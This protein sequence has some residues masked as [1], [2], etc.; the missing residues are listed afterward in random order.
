MAGTFALAAVAGEL[1]FF[2]PIVGSNPNVTIAGVPSGGLPW[3][4]HGSAVLNDDGRLSVDIDDLILPSVG[5]PGPVT[6]VDASVV[7]SDAVAATSNAVNLS[8]EG[9]ARIHAKLQLPSPCF[10]PIVLIRLAGANN[11]PVANGPWIA[12]TGLV[13]DN[14]HDKD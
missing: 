12:A 4:T 14:D 1:V 11:T 6:Q 7:C 9:N 10:G 13:K 8:A 3:T 5:S 2:S